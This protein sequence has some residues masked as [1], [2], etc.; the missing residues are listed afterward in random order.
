MQ[1]EQLTVDNIENKAFNNSIIRYL[2]ILD[3]KIASLRD[4]EIN[5]VSNNFLTIQT[6]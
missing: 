5:Y 1:R 4:F 6:R 3:Q 2:L